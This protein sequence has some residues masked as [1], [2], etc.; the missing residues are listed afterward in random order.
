MKKFFQKNPLR[1]FY[2]D[3]WRRP[4]LVGVTVGVLC[5]VAMASG[6][7]LSWKWRLADRMYLPHASSPRIVLVVIDD[8]SLARIGRWPWDRSVHA[9]LIGKISAGNPSAIGYDISFPEPSDDRNDGALEEAMRASGKVVLPVELSLNDRSNRVEYDPLR[10][11]APISR[12]GAAAA[13]TGFA[14][15]PLDSDGVMRRVP[16]NAFSPDGSSIDAF[17]SQIAVVGGLTV[18]AHQ[19]TDA[20]S[21]LLVNFPDVPKKGFFTVSAS[22]VI[23]G[24]IP[25]ERFTDAFVL[26]GA[27][28]SSLHDEQLTAASHAE[29]MSGIQIQAS[30][31]DTLLQ[32]RFLYEFPMAGTVC[33]LI[34][35][36]AMLG[37]I[38]PRVRARY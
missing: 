8:A 6:V 38:L 35:L 12:L 16:L 5:A 17:A 4:A 36:G 31:L 10:V 11:I 3:D 20:A 9:D 26:V 15:T 30:V 27:T 23:D 29:P 22:E 24:N 37:L 21:R 13:R 32:K 25:S 33:W 18:D 34:L 7:L 28:A 2:K 14:N 19:G 1:A